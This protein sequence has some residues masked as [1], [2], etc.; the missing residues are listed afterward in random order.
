MMFSGERATEV[1][2]AALDHALSL[3]QRLA[4]KVHL[5]MCKFCSRF[6]QQMLFLRNAMHK[7]SERGA[8]TGFMPEHSLTEEACE[9][10]RNALREHKSH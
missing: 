7:Y 8:E 2:S 3:H 4:L 1:M 10:I 9:R 6:W 5:F